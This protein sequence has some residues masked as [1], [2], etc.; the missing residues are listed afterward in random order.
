M[1][2]VSVVKLAELISAL[3]EQQGVLS[4]DAI[5]LRR[6]EK[7]QSYDNKSQKDYTVLLLL[8]STA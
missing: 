6:G 4:R 5:I 8:L 3:N 1:V 2:A 7:Q